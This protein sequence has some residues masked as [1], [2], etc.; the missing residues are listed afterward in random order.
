MQ[1]YTFNLTPGNG[2]ATTLQTVGNLFVYE[3]ATTTGDVRV[4]VKPDSGGEII[5]KPGQRF[6]P[7]KPA[8]QWQ[9]RMVGTDP[10]AGTFIIGEGDFDDANTLNR[11]T[12]DASFANNVTVMNDSAHRVPVSLDPNQLLQNSA[13]IMTY[14]TAKNKLTVGTAS[15]DVVELLAP[16]DNLN[17]AVVEQTY[18]AGTNFTAYMWAK[19]VKPT[20]TSDTAGDVINFLDSSA[21][22]IDRTRIKVAAGKGIYVVG[23]GSYS[24]IVSALLTVL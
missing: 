13:P 8:M 5:L 19:A 2:Q 15:T 16:T 17:G 20:T 18:A 11:V 21:R 3:S 23:S 22:P 4:S 9:V 6:R 10:L 7:A 12:L 24:G 1:S 14:T